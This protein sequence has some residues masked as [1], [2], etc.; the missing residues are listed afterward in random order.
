[1]SLERLIVISIQEKLGE[2]FDDFLHARLL[3]ASI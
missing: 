1:M 2:K 3:C